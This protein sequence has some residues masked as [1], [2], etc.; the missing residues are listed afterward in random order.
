MD[1]NGDLMKHTY[2]FSLILL[3]LVILVTLA[4]FLL[5]VQSGVRYEISYP[6]M[7]ILAPAKIETQEYFSDKP[8]EALVMYDSNAFAGVEHVNTVLDVLDSMEV[9]YDKFDVSSD[10]EY[11]LS[12]YKNVVVSFIDLQK[13]EDHL[14]GL[15]NWVEGGGHLLFSIRPDPSS[16]FNAIYRK[17]GIVSKSDGLIVVRGVDFISDLMPGAEGLKVGADFIDSNS[18]FVELE[19]ECKVHLK[20]TDEFQAPI[21]WECDYQMGRFVILNSDQFNTKSDRGVIGAAYSLLQDVFVYPVING[22]IYFINEFPSPIKQGTDDF[23]AKQFG[24]DIQNFYVNVW[25]PDIQQLSHKYG[26]KY[27]GAFLETFNDTVLPPF[28]KQPENEKYGYFGGLILNNKGEVGI[29]GYNHVPL[30]L[31]EA[32]INQKL[33]YPGWPSLESMELSIYESYSF[34][35][36]IFP[37]NKITTYIPPSNILCPDAR[38]WLPQALPDLQVIS[39]L[40]LPGEGGLAYEQEY[41]EAADGIIELPRIAGGYELSSYLRWASINELG[42]HYINSYYISPDDV[43]SDAYGPQKG[44]DYLHGQFEEYVK[45]LSETTPS[46]RNLTALEGAMAVQR[47]ARLAVKTEKE[48]GEV[49][50]SLGNF[51]DEAWLMMRSSKAPQSIDGGVVTQVSSSLY[52]IQALKPYIVVRFTE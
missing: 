31:A 50:I 37:D 13:H 45:R 48:D 26:I 32:E 14:S 24:R 10:R 9:K 51:Y 7:H 29:H 21:L 8:V 47:F 22:S 46:L 43:L 25:W 42:L 52:L 6:P 4:S 1:E 44:W 35:K 5:I 27:T 16:A 28:N 3:P 40:Y 12:K 49:D 39:S 30:C 19:P 34:T 38:H 33:D 23:I 41:T 11:D 36:S 2:S 17:L 18:Y 20:S 15:L